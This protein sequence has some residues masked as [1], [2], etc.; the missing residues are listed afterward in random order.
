MRGG[1]ALTCDNSTAVVVNP[2]TL[3]NRSHEGFVIGWTSIFVIKYLAFTDSSVT[4]VFFDTAPVRHI[5]A[6]APR[7]IPPDLPSL[8]RPA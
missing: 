3:T 1:I 7:R 2:G 4:L 5:R 6:T 8:L